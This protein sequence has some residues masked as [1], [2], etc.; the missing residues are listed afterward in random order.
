MSRHPLVK[1]A[2]R[3]DKLFVTVELPDAKNVKLNLDPE[4]KFFFSATGGVDNVPYEIDI[5]LYDKVVVDESK[6]SCTSRHIC[7][8]V[9]KAESKWW[10][11]LLKQGGKPPLF[12]KVD[13]DKWVD[14]DEQ[15]EKSAGDTGFGDFNFSV[16][17]YIAM[18]LL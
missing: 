6:A 7:Y 10:S 15:D 4:G 1:W 9:K 12:L 18:E 2:Q 14:E 5:D 16:S 8:L 13:W 11:R 3:S 17:R